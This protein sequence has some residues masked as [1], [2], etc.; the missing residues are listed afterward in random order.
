MWLLFEQAPAAIIFADRGG[1]VREWNV[2]ATAIF[3]HT[4]ADAIGQSLDLIISERVREAHWRGLSGRS[5]AER[6]RTAANCCRCGSARRDG[7]TIYVDLTFAIIHDAGGAV[8][9]ALAHARDI[10]ERWARERAQRE[11]LQELEARLS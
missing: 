11:R 1:A 2:A 6:Q 5:L 10:S 9:G 4:A 3:G 8:V 7:G